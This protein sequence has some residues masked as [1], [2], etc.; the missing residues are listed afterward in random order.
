MTAV[1][2]KSELVKWRSGERIDYY[3]IIAG[4]IEGKKELR[5]EGFLVADINDFI[6]QPL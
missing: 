5:R 1:R 3:G 2:T 6:L 4:D